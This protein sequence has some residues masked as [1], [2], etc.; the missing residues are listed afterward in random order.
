MLNSSSASL[1]RRVTAAGIS[2]TFGLA[3]AYA[4][5]NNPI[6]VGG[7]VQQADRTAA[8]AP[9]Y[10][11]EAKEKRIEGTVSLEIL[12]NKDGRVAHASLISGPPELVQAS[13][14]AVLQWVY[15]PTLLN[16]QP[17]EVVTTVDIKFTLAD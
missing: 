7:N 9:S 10:P 13:V 11:A 2:L 16:G 17:V 12:I 3:F 14:D 4:Q 6:R 8:V 15:K 5:A 1:L